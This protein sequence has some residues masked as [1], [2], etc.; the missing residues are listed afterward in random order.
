MRT[1][2]RFLLLVTVCLFLLPAIAGAETLTQNFDHKLGMNQAAQSWEHRIDLPDAMAQKGMSF[3]R[4]SLTLSGKLV[5]E[6]EELT[7]TY[8][9]VRVHLPKAVFG[10]KGTLNVRLEAVENMPPCAPVARPTGLAL[11]KN[12]DPT[13]PT[14]TWSGLGKYAAVTLYDV[15]AN[16]TVFER[17]VLN[18]RSCEMDEGRL[19]I[20]HHYKWA[21]CES[22]ECARYSPE[23]QAGFRLE[24]RTERC[25]T[26]NGYGWVRCNT[27]NGTGII[28]VQGQ[29]GQPIQTLCNWCRGTGRQTCNICLGSGRV[30]RPIAIPE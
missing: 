24:L 9:Y 29:N 6:R 26:C 16:K 20:D 19:P 15:T 14:F 12:S 30:E 5:I 13:A 17:I 10:S 11:A 22:D 3:F 8:Y 7:P 21:V 23:A 25:W 2:V 28:V 18:T 4:R 27:C 1:L